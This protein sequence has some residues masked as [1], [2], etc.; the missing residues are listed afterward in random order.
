MQTEHCDTFF[1]NLRFFITYNSITNGQKY[2][3]NTID[4]QIH[5]TKVLLQLCWAARNSYTL[6]FI[7]VYMLI[8]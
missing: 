4:S 8:I 5:H 3:I 6:S 1:S 2:E 7:R